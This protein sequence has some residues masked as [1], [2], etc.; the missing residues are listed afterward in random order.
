VLGGDLVDG[1]EDAVAAL[2]RV[3][4]DGGRAGV[5]VRHPEASRPVLA[6]QEPGC[7]RRRDEHGEFLRLRDREQAPLELLAA[8]EAVVG[9]DADEARQHQLSRRDA[10]LHQP[11]R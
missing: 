4:L 9:L 11:L 7:E 2:V 10:R 5:G 6:G 3:L 1:G 8:H